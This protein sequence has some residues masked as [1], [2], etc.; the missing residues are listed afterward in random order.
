MLPAD[1]NEITQYSEYPFPIRQGIAEVLR[2]GAGIAL[3]DLPFLPALI[4]QLG[5]LGSSE[6]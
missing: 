2:A 1:E 6:Q 5:R 3:G 4:G